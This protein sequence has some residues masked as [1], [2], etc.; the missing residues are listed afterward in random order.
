VIATLAAALTSCPAILEQRESS[1]RPE[2]TFRPNVL[3]FLTDDQRTG[4]RVMPAVRRW[5]RERGTTFRNAFTTTPSCCP[6]RAS[7]LTGQYAHN[8]NVKDNFHPQRL[9]QRRTI[10]F[11]LSQAGYRTGII[12]KYLNRW[13]IARPP[14][15][16][17]SWTIYG[18]SRD[19]GYYSG[20]LWNVSGR[21]LRVGTYATSFI[22]RQTLRWL[23]DTEGADRKPWFLIVAP[24]APHAPYVSERRYR[25][26][27]VGRWRPSPAALETDLSDKPAY[28]QRQVATL[29]T[30]SRVRKGQIRTLMSVN[31]LVDDVMLRLRDLGEANRTLAFYLSDNGI[32]WSEHNVYE[33]RVPY[34]PAIRIPM[35]LRWPRHVSPGAV[36][37]RLVANI[38]VA[39]T[40]LAA[41]GL[42]E[43]T[44]HLDGQSLLA[45]GRRKAL[46]I[47]YWREPRK[48]FP[49]W[50]SV[51]AESLQYVE[52]VDGSRELYDLRHDPWQLRNLLDDSSPGSSP[53]VGPLRDWAERQRSCAGKACLRDRSSLLGQHLRRLSK[54]LEDA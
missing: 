7:L 39:P 17:G 20:G 27:P 11:Y 48:P 21:V 28:V 33:K 37:D 19:S 15:Y 36:D 52:Y 34:T 44:D 5:F 9:E 51:R 32:L 31:D 43:V 10:E 16:F 1:T 12:G 2:S 54:E 29:R 49:T 50:L 25:R 41:V 4:L 38:D 26:A 46:L 24:T 45:P 42:D 40:I 47:E 53:E 23:E 18:A 30:A 22:A 3:I 6:S 13:P 8:H 35:L 14:P